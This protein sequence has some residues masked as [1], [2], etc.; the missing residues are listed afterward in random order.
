MGCCFYYNGLKAR[1]ARCIQVLT[2]LIGV[3]ILHTRSKIFQKDHPIGWLLLRLEFNWMVG[4]RRKTSF[5]M[6][7][8]ISPNINCSKSID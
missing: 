6:V 8:T 1:P 3:V 2:F 5:L 4:T 7:R